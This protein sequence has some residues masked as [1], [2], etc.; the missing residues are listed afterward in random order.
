[1]LLVLLGAIIYN[2]VADTAVAYFMGIRSKKG[3]T[4]IAFT[5]VL[6][7]LFL[8]NP[9]LMFVI[10]SALVYICALPV[11]AAAA[12]AAEAVVYYIFSRTIPHPIKVAVT[13]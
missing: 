8:T 1:M 11:L 5:N 13:I 9:C 3:M 7:T 10:G 12:T 6:T 4:V 2:A